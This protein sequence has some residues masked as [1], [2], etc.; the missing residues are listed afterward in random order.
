MFTNL[1]KVLSDFRLFSLRHLC[2]CVCG[3]LPPV[4]KVRIALITWHIARP[5]LHPSGWTSSVT[6]LCAKT[7]ASR[8]FPF[9]VWVHRWGKAGGAPT[10]QRRKPRRCCAGGGG[11]S[12]SSSISSLHTEEIIRDTGGWIRTLTDGSRIGRG[13]ARGESRAEGRMEPEPS[14]T[15]GV[16]S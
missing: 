5:N 10:N 14:R 15:T 6:C 11:R 3:G 9:D 13:E 7:C 12:S 8:G 16:R 2:V 4:Y 1:K